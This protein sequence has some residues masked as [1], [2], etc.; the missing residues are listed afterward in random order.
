M[1]SAFQIIIGRP[2][3]RKTDCA[4]AVLSCGARPPGAGLVFPK[5]AGPGAGWSI[6]SSLAPGL[7]PSERAEARGAA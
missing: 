6:C 3:R 1:I 2:K 4:V 5:D 7:R